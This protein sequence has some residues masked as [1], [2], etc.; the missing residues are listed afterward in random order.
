MET[1]RISDDQQLR[2]I[3]EKFVEKFPHLRLEFFSEAHG[4]GEASTYK[5]KYDD[6]LLLK[7]IRSIHNEGDLSIDGQT[8]TGDFESGFKSLF[9]VNVQVLRKAGNMWIQ[10]T[11]TDRWTLDQQEKESK[12][13]GLYK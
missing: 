12:E 13:K 4:L 1:M 3:K 7:D 9:G 5:T 11:T 10:T 8:L 6:E 2:E